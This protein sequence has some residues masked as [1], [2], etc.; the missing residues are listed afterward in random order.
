M[1][2]GALNA[3]L[4]FVFQGFSKLFG[5]KLR[6]PRKEGLSCLLEAA[7]Y[8]NSFEI[9]ISEIA[10]PNKHSVTWQ[11]AVRRMV[12]VNIHYLGKVGERCFLTPNCETEEVGSDPE[13]AFQWSVTLT[14]NDER[15]S[16]AV[17]LFQP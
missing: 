14:N 12:C 4:C 3:R 16:K 7:K 13:S 11:I 15:P 9:N 5:G 2:K 6:I 1:S 10:W 8:G 17:L